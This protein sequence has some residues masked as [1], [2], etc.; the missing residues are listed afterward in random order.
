MLPMQSGQNGHHGVNAQWSV[1]E[2]KEA[3]EEN[4][5]L[6]LLREPTMK[7]PNV[8]ES[9][10]CLRGAMTALAQNGLNG[11]HGQSAL[12]LVARMQSGKGKENA[13]LIMQDLDW[14]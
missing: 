7:N 3:K 5:Y 2:E 6:E 13:S 9:Q 4:A 10:K 11:A 12:K 1:A 8:R 14:S